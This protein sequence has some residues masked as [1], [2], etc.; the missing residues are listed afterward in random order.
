MKIGSVS[1]DHWEILMS[2][3]SK[4]IE[5]A[6]TLDR[7]AKKYHDIFIAAHHVSGAEVLVR[8]IYEKIIATQNAMERKYPGEGL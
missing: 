5:K 8:R 2:R 7:T 4:N 6:Q 1:L 3:K